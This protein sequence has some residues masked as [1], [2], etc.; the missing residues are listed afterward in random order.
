MSERS[1][2]VSASELSYLTAQV[3]TLENRLRE[4][5][6]STLNLLVKSVSKINNYSIKYKPSFFKRN[7]IK[8]WRM[9]STN[10]SRN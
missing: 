10:Y 4:E 5:I 8:V 9:K 3:W 6:R 2:E 1:S 7:R